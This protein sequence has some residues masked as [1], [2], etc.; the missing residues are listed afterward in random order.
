MFGG[1]ARD[2]VGSN[3][4]ISG[5]SCLRRVD[6]WAMR[7]SR[8]PSDVVRFSADNMIRSDLCAGP[9]VELKT[10]ISGAEAQAVV[11]G[12]QARRST[13]TAAGGFPNLQ[14]KD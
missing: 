2:W 4:L 3:P 8:L 6:S 5:F 9:I 7:A 14:R 1:A 10:I 13:A 11:L 12:Q